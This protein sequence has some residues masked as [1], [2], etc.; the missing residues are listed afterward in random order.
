M[1]E[2]V[3]VHGS[4]KDEGKRYGVSMGINVRHLAVR[5]QVLGT[6]RQVFKI[7]F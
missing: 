6:T 1:R 3:S 2:D 7:R 4:G 5:Y